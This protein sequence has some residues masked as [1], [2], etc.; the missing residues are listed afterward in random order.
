M[1]RKEWVHRGARRFLYVADPWELP[2]KSGLVAWYDAADRA[3]ITDAGAGAVS[4]WTDKSGNGYTLTEATNRPTTGTRS[5][6]GLNVIDFDGTNDKLS[7][8]CPADDISSC[9]FVV[10]KVDSLTDYRTLVA[11]NGNDA[12]CVRVNQTSGTIQNE[13]QGLNGG[14]LTVVGIGTSAPFWVY[15]YWNGS[16]NVGVIAANSAGANFSAGAN[17]AA[18]FSSFT[19][20]RTLVIGASNTTFFFD[21]WIGEIIRYNTVLS[22]PN[23][24]LVVQYLTT[25]WGF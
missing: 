22:G 16:S 5:Q 12:D 20:G 18:T 6:N 25:K 19:A 23:F 24:A 9:T 8:S 3:T 14:A 2:V 4:A 17:M 21:G 11:G 15:S 10:A 1:R 13:R 7:S